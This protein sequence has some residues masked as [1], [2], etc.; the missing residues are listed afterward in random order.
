MIGG[1]L[2]YGE[3]PE[4]GLLREVLEETGVACRI[5]A[6]NCINADHYGPGGPALLN[7]S[8]TVELLSDD[9]RPQDDVSELKWFPLTELPPDLSFES[10]RRALETLRRRWATADG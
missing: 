1:F 7:I 8:F 9:F 6:F 10:D 5:K 2:D 3:N 4:A